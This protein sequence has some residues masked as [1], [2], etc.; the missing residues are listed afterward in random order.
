MVGTAQVDN[1]IVFI[2]KIGYSVGLESLLRRATDFG[3]RYAA[4]PSFRESDWTSLVHDKDKWNLKTSNVGDV[5]AELGIAKVRNREVFPGPIGESLGISRKLLPD[6]EYKRAC[7]FLVALAIVTADGDIFLNALRSKFDKEA[8]SKALILMIGEKRNA[9]FEIFRNTP[10]REAVAGAV[11]IERQRTNKGGGSPGGLAGVAKG[12]PLSERTQGLGLPQPLNINSVETP[13]KDYLHKITI[14]RKGWAESLGL[15]SGEDLTDAGFAFLLRLSQAGLSSKDGTFCVWPTAFDLES[16]QFDSKA[17]DILH[18]LSTWQFQLAVFRAMGGH[19]AASTPNATDI[20][21]AA[22]LIAEIYRAYRDLSQNRR[23]I[24]NEV[25]K[26][27]ISAV[28]LARALSL[29]IPALDIDAVIESPLL[30]GH[31]V[32]VRISKTIEQAITVRTHA[33]QTA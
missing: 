33:S 22:Q 1:Y 30:L 5:F 28:F 4:V 16:N 2:R 8:T 29:E 13:S 7:R 19:V 26:Q 3:A 6:S 18:P 24:R 31:G 9:L 20:N 10:E 27:V 21:R 32:T 15:F 12:L 17:F 25:P 14:S 23:M 11:S